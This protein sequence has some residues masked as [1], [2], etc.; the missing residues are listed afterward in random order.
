MGDNPLTQDEINAI[1]NCRYFGE[2][3]GTKEDGL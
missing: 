2:Y 3:W 1:Y